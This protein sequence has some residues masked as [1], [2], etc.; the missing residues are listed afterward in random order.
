MTENPLE[1]IEPYQA[2]GVVFH[3]LKSCRATTIGQVWMQRLIQERSDVPILHLESD[4][5]DV[6]DMSTS[7]WTAKIEAF[8]EVVDAR[9]RRKKQMS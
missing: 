6:R 4:T 2:D 8:M 7:E 5:C 1:Y 3:W 9:K